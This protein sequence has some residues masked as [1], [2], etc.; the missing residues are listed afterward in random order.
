MHARKMMVTTALSMAITAGAGVLAQSA[1]TPPTEGQKGSQAMSM[2]DMTKQCRDHCTKASKSMDETMKMLND[3][4]QSNDVNKMRT[5]IDQ[6][7]KQMTSMKGH[8]D[9]C[10]NM[11]DMM[12]RMGGMMKK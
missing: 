4:Q 3:A 7:Q 6:T 1:K 8:M 12:Q 5:A 10:M 11:M 2:A 9:M